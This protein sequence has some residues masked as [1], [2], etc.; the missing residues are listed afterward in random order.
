M[1]PA[2]VA[3]ICQAG[4]CFQVAGEQLHAVYVVAMQNGVA[5]ITALQ[6]ESGG[7]DV[8]GLVDQLVSAQAQGHKAIALQTMRR[9]LVRRLERHGYQVA[10]W[11]LKKDLK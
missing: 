1:T 6:G 9:G 4:E 2:A 3:A 10:G 5:W 8:V 11:V 7:A